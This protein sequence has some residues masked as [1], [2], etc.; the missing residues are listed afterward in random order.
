M[1]FTLRDGQLLKDGM[2]WRA[3]GVNYHPSAAGC[4]IWLDWNVVAIEH[5]FRTI[6]GHGLNT[7]RVFVFW[8]D[9]EPEEGCHDTEVLG[10]V[11]TLV[12]LAERYGLACV[13]SV[14][15]IWMNGERLDLSW[16]RG[17]NLW[18]DPVLL[19]RGEAYLRAL[20]HVLRGLDNVLALDLGDEIGNIDPG[21][22]AA[23]DRTE[24]ADWQ[25]R[26]STAAR[27]ILPGVLVCQANDV[28][29]VL[30]SASFGP[31]N[32]VGLDVH[33]VHGWP[34]WTPGA[35][36][37]TASLKASQLPSFLVGYASAYGPALV[38]ELGSYGVSDTIAAGYQ[39]AGGAAA[40][41]SGAVGVLAWCWQDITSTAPPYDTRPAERVAGLLRADGTERPALTALV[42]TARLAALLNDFRPDRPR[43]ALYLPESAR[44][45]NSSYLDAPVGTVATFFASLLLRRAGLPHRVVAGDVGDADLLVVPSV[46]RLTLRDQDRLRDHLERGGT[47]YL[48]V[49]DHVG[50]LPGADL[51]GVEPVDFTLVDDDDHHQRLRWVAQEGGPGG[52]WPLAPTPVRQVVVRPTTAR[53]LA[54]LADDIPAC[55]V[56][57]VGPGRFIVA[58]VPVELQLD[59]P[60]ALEDTDLHTLYATIAGLAGIT[61]PMAT[62]PEVEV[63]TG[64]ID[65]QPA[66]VLVNHGITASPLPGRRLAVPAKGW[67]VL[68]SGQLLAQAG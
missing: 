52:E 48:S 22:S 60:G 31:D 54:V 59:R 12:E 8:R 27:E 46:A 68:R 55:T 38:D 6:A 43:V 18:R 25:T 42:D 65:G 62:P 14:F 28:S 29:G 3:V 39:R 45:A 47:V 5:D 16:R 61:P 30:R 20:A 49:A 10:H 32:G 11:R 41:A 53:V 19:D 7:V 50:G 9:V 13:V 21:A 57:N 4:R 66:T 37:S 51:T 2:P 35:V 26:M 23:P 56:N 33:A 58:T 36:E 67:L 1:T 15:T 34:L 17:R 63:V 64:T 44:T 24:V 40:L